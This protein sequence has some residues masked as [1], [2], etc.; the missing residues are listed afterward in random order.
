MITIVI[1]MIITMCGQ[2]AYLNHYSED[3][4]RQDEKDSQSQQQRN[5]RSAHDDVNHASPST[6]S[7]SNACCY[8]NLGSSPPQ[9]QS[10]QHRHHHQEVPYSMPQ[11]HRSAVP[12][13]PPAWHDHQNVTE[14]IEN[15]H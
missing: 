1:L 9:H 15:N 8:C 7:S 10:P 11:L 4:N 14:E 6:S 3:A 2:I 12:Q 5:H 13:G